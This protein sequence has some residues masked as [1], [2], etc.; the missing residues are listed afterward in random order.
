M[1]VSQ[2]PAA[3][4]P[5]LLADGNG[6]VIVQP[7]M[8]DMLESHR[9]YKFPLRCLPAGGV[10][11]PSPGNPHT[12]NTPDNTK[13]GW[14]PASDPIFKGTAPSVA[15]FGYNWSKASFAK[16]W[17]PIPLSGVYIDFDRGN[18]P[19]Q[20]F[21]GAPL[22]TQG[23][24]YCDRNGIWWT[25]DCYGDVPWPTTLTT[26]EEAS[27]LSQD[28][29]IAECPRDL[30]MAMNL[31]FTAPTFQN[32]GTVVTSL[33][34]GAG[35]LLS[36]KCQGTGAPAATGPLE[37]DLNL[38]FT[39]GPNNVPGY[40]VLKSVSGT[41]FSSGPVLEGVRS[42]TSNLTITGTASRA[43]DPADPN[44]TAFAQG[45]CT[46]SVST[47]V[48]GTELPIELVR[49][50][51]AMEQFYQSLMELGFPVGKASQL[52]G[53]F[54]VPVGGV[55]ANSNIA[56]RMR[57]LGRA[58][59][60]LPVL[61]FGYRRIP[62]PVPA[63]TPLAL[64]L[65]DTTLAMPAGLAVGVDQYVEVLGPV[66]QVQP[67]DVVQFSLGRNASDGYTGDVLLLH[68]AAVFQ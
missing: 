12:I 46:L 16:L 27:L 62:R 22:G 33:V 29:D 50:S 56:L 7:Q 8:R 30:R 44:Q 49:L 40:N 41:V 53:K 15:V 26:A 52:R 65:V 43:A 58:A 68:Q 42:S 4:V 57:L 38:A 5:V 37:I 11:P 13:E 3:S 51:A 23:L 32:T 66:F 60:T 18:D 31:Y 19:T 55:P 9:H 67:G 63:A 35:G 21:H 20:G 36:V 6:N 64:P 34:A 2:K 17:P 14:L 24:V 28:S 45:L 25:S 10:I 54:Y 59:G 61:T 1:L 47:A 39:S 48:G